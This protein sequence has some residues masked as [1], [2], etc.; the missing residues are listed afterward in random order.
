MKEYKLPFD[1][2]G[3]ERKIGKF[4]A[5]VLG[6]LLLMASPFMAYSALHFLIQ[7][8]SSK[9]LVIDR[10]PFNRGSNIRY[11]YRTQSGILEKGED[12]L[13]ALDPQMPNVGDTI[14]I[15]YFDDGKSSYL[16]IMDN[17]LLPL[18]SFSMGFIILR[19]V[20][21]KKIKS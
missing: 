4:V 19:S 14:S 20:L 10:H 1:T 5:F 13:I 18:L 16:T 21:S 12:H 8:K 9:A 3:A 15:R 2:P 6:F 17:A 11:E 7:G